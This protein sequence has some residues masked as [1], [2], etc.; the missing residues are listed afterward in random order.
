MTESGLKAVFLKERPMLMR[1]LV[2]RLGGREEAEDALQDMW[3][4]LD[5]LTAKPIAQPAAYLYRMASNL[6]SDRRLSAARSNARDTAWRD[7]QPAA[8]ELPGIE[9]AL[10]ARERL[11]RIDA[12]LAAMPERMRLAFRMFRIDEISQKEISERL[13]ITVSGV[14]KLLKRAYR[15]IYDEAPSAGEGGQD[16]HRLAKEEDMHRDR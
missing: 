10:I 8:E 14:E 6:A 11:T 1:L 7:A 12:T 16:R 2:A 9:R 5:Q 4:K 13:G 3:L 15:Q